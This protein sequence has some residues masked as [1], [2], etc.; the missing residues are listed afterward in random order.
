MP[1]G[2]S[3]GS[4]EIAAA[5]ARAAA[6]KQAEDVVVL[7]VHDLIVIT[8]LFVICTGTSDRHV[9]TVVEEVEKALRGLGQKPVRREGE[10]EARWV[11]LD[12]VDVVVHVFAEEERDYYDLER[13]WRDAPRLVWDGEGNGVVASAG[14]LD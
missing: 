5:A 6:D 4:R 2:S 12:Y 10:Q 9:K 8:D 14:S 1:S 3:A 13:L 7:D 11:L